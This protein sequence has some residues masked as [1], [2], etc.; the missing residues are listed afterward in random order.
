MNKEKVS[1]RFFVIACQSRPSD[2]V[3]FS[4]A[5]RLL[6]LEKPGPGAFLI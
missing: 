5:G 1:G 3:F 6:F 2:P 4:I